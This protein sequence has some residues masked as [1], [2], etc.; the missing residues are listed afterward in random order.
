MLQIIIAVSKSKKAAQ[1]R[2]LNAN[3]VNNNIDKDP[4]D[5][6][7]EK[8]VEF[9]NQEE[10]RKIFSDFLAKRRREEQRRYNLKP[11]N[12]QQML[13][14][15]EEIDEES[16]YEDDNINEDFNDDYIDDFEDETRK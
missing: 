5:P 16:D 2:M 13:N 7:T 11:S 8:A 10:Q 9:V 4:H 14:S 15:F 3:T 6:V 1:R 12:K